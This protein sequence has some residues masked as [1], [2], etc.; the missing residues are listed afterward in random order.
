MPHVNF[1]LLALLASLLLNFIIF[2]ANAD[3]YSECVYSWEFG[4][5]DRKM[6]IVRP[7][8]QICYK[9]CQ[10]ECNAFG[11][12]DPTEI[13]EDQ[14]AFNNAAN[15]VDDNLNA[16]IID[17][18]IFHCQKGEFFTSN[19]REY[20][21]EG[22]IVWSANKATTKVSCSMS[23][24][25]SA[26]Y[27]Y[28]PSDLVVDPTK[29]TEKETIK[30]QMINQSGNGEIGNSIYLCGFKTLQLTPVWDSVL[31][32]EWPNTSEINK[33]ISNDKLDW[34]AK[35][36]NWTDTGIDIK[37][38]DYLEI[39]YG[40]SYIFDPSQ[41]GY[42]SI[43]N[44]S[45]HIW[46]PASPLGSFFYGWKA[47]ELIGSQLILPEM[48]IISRD[49]DGV[50]TE[51]DYGDVEGITNANNALRF[52]GLRARIWSESRELPESYKALG[53][54]M[55]HLLS[56]ITDP[57]ESDNI[58]F[59]TKERLRMLTFSGKLDGFSTEY[60]RLGLRHYD[61]FNTYN[62]LGHSVY[63]NNIGG[64]NVS[65]KWRGCNFR[66]GERLQYAI[67]PIDDSNEYQPES[68]STEWYDVD[69]SSGFFEPKGKA[70]GNIFFRIKKLDLLY[71]DGKIPICFNSGS[72][73]CA[74]TIANITDESKYASYNTS[75][76]YYIT[77]ERKATKAP[78]STGLSS[79][80][81]EISN[82]FFSDDLTNPRYGTVQ[83][84]F[85][86]LVLDTN[87]LDAIRAL[88]VLYIAF[89][90]LS[91]VIGLAQLTQQEAVF[92]ILKI[93]IV[94][95][96]ISDGGWDFFNNYLFNF[97]RVGSLELIL[98]IA[99]SMT[100][101]MDFTEQDLLNN[102]GI[103]FSVFDGPFRQ[104]FSAQV[105]IKIASLICASLFGFIIAIAIIFA[106]VL[107]IM[108]IAK[109]LM[110]Y[111]MSIISLGILF[112]I[113]PIFICF[114]L[115]E[116]TKSFFDG[117]IKQMLSFALQPVF[118]I[119]SVAFFNTLLMTA[120]YMTL[121]FTACKICLLGFSIIGFDVCII[122]GY[123]SAI[124]AHHPNA[125]AFGIP[126]N[127]VAS[128]IIFLI[129]GQ[130]MYVFCDF[131][132]SLA[133]MIATSSFIGMNLSEAASDANPVNHW[134][135]SFTAQKKNST[136]KKRAPVGAANN[137]SNQRRAPVGIANNA[138]NQR[139]APA[140]DDA[141]IEMGDQ[142]D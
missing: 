127:S 3:I 95:V 18:C 25:S 7:V 69:M 44:Q 112:L 19:Y 57:T 46:R 102:P 41:T 94:I 80:V 103:V 43:Y 122:P 120:L 87:F 105:W 68:P 40:G 139:G 116:Y 134:I 42:N 86:R 74:S 32:S 16:D 56:W 59:R 2:E 8:G 104:L 101:S 10:N 52:Y 129:I 39:K 89:T 110:L 53:A 121:G 92:R 23:G 54:T 125:N 36:H 124:T 4:D 99:G 37:D 65:V 111:L 60:M 63:A 62:I 50:P 133:N 11:R 79:I 31:G 22:K 142:R 113:A 130:A 77:V 17:S 90:G 67:V 138:Q 114:L 38:G 137:A 108:C 135:S 83:K 45:L 119:V 76:E 12:K 29:A 97:L 128:A 141:I 75:G 78:I 107:Y 14:D 85:K 126:I 72:S 6:V 88:L 96:L 51:I 61:N 27:N 28:Y 81:N 66:S 93:S 131:S 70:K 115:F 26:T 34:H 106:I 91:F 47:E 58:T 55:P 15:G 82:Y 64:M 5:E 9:R 48:K 24:I 71:N 100:P 49:D 13:V 123:M 98:R 84:I 1:K 35:N 21:E 140:N 136:D 118:V 33:R 73:P 109:V 20:N 117:W 132:S 30:I